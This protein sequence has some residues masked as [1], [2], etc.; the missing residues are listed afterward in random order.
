MTV[1][2]AWPQANEDLYAGGHDSRS[3]QIDDIKKQLMIAQDQWDRTKTGVFEI[4]T[5][6]GTASGAA[7]GRTDAHS[8][9]MESVDQLLLKAMTFYDNTRQT[10][11]NAKQR[12]I[13]ICNYYQS[14]IDRLNEEDLEEDRTTA[15]N[16]LIQ[17]ALKANS[18]VV[19]AAAMAVRNGEVYSPPEIA[20]HGDPV[21]RTPNEC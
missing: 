21:F 5:W 16:A 7:K 9:D 3:Q 19:D 4:S 11:I 8:G 1:P 12:I 18:D 14:E 20:T 17:A 6:S 2:P 10:I 15:I 13:D